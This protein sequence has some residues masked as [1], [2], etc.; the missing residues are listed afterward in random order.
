MS[1]S[2]KFF[3]L[4]AE[5]MQRARRWKHTGNAYMTREC[6]AQARACH[7]MARKAL[8]RGK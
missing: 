7:R 1:K 3:Q 8:R 6:V 4:S 5:A 2:S